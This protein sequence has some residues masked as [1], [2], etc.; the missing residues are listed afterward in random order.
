M[1]WAIFPSG[2]SEQADK[3]AAEWRRAG[4]EVA[5]LIDA[6]Q[7]PV[8]C[9]RLFIE[10]DYRGTAAAFN[11]MIRELDGDLFLCLNDDVFP[12]PGA[13]ADNFGR[14]FRERFP[15]GFGVMQATGAWYDA[16]AWCAPYPLIGAKYAATKPWH[17]GYYHLHCDQELRDVAIRRNAYAECPEVAIEHRHYTMGHAD[18]LPAEK[19]A[20]NRARH[21]ADAKLYEARKAA[22]FP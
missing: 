22:G 15:D 20:K 6:G 18:T 19:R 12:G 16:M 7:T 8:K 17:E 4:Y 11:R 9:E 10:P 21:L 13:D 5:V 2:N 3:C 1:I 14:I